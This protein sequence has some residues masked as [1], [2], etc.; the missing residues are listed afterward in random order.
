MTQIVVSSD[1]FSPPSTER[2]GKNTLWALNRLHLHPWWWVVCIIQ[3]CFTAWFKILWFIL[4]C[5]F[6]Y[7]WFVSGW[8]N[9]NNTATEWK[10]WQITAEVEPLWTAK[11]VPFTWAHP[12]TRKT[13]FYQHSWPTDITTCHSLLVQVHV[14]VFNFCPVIF[15]I[16]N[17]S[18]FGVV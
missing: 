9:W 15:A 17:A 1:W 3:G 11:I 13:I 5:S 10:R 12:S 2:L 8:I 4:S 18:L 16:K 6:K 7:S 14:I